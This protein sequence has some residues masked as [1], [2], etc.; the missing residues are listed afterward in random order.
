MITFPEILKAPANKAGIQMPDDVSRYEEY[1]ELYPHF[2]VFCRMQLGSPMPYPSVHFD[3]AKIIAL[4]TEEDFLTLTYEDIVNHGF[5]IGFD[6]KE[7]HE[8]NWVIKILKL[9]GVA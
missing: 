8:N 7:N 5:Q 4:F 2:F 9:I 6:I 3:N 1:A